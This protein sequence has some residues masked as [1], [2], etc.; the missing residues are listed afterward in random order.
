MLYPSYCASVV[1]SDFVMYSI[2]LFRDHCVLELVDNCTFEYIFLLTCSR[3]YH[4][5]VGYY[6]VNLMSFL[7]VCALFC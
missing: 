4:L 5:I 1:D 6:I 7:I 2:Y 3:T